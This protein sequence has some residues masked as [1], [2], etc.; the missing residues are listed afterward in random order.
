MPDEARAMGGVGGVEHLLRPQTADVLPLAEAHGVGIIVREPLAN[1]RLT[2]TFH[3]D[4]V[5]GPEDRR[6]FW[7]RERVIQDAE[8]VERLAV[9][10]GDGR[11]TAPQAALQWIL[12][13]GAVATVIPGAMSIAEL[14]ESLAVPDLPPLTA[15]ELNRVRPLQATW[16]AVR[17]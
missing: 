3:R 7:P 14:R 6:R 8:R 2:D 16:A 13:H 1:G 17:V 11:R 12:T 4:I 15:E 5:F 10:W 9:L